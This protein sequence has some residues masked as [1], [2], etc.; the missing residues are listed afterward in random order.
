MAGITG[1]VLFSFGTEK[2]AYNSFSSNYLIYAIKSNLVEVLAQSLKIH[3]DIV[4][5]NQLY[6]YY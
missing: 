3:A 6:C 5:K 4:I 1:V 2:K